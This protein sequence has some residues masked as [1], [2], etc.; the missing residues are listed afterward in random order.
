MEITAL[1]Y[2]DNHLDPDIARMCQNQLLACRVKIISV[3]LEPIDFGDTRIVLPLRRGY[4]T[5]FKQILAGLEVCAGDVVF[6]CEHDILYHPSHF[7]FSPASCQTFYYN[8]NVWKVDYVTGHALFCDNT[9]QTSGLCACR[10]LLLE[11]YRQRVERVHLEGKFDYRIGFEPGTHSLPRGIDNH[12]AASW[13]SGHPNIDIR[14]A[15]NLTPSRWSKDQ[16]RNPKYTRGWKEME[17]GN[18][19]THLPISLINTI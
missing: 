14:H 6:F 3:S 18:N 4:L 2:T 10:E 5:M 15:N 1:Y 11:H 17:L 13:I 9:Q 8:T 16:F 12:P 19:W 7:D